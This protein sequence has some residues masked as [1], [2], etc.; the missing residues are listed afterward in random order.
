MHASTCAKSWLPVVVPRNH[1]EPI[2][3]IPGQERGQELPLAAPPQYL[4]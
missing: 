4:Y 1:N 2:R 3:L